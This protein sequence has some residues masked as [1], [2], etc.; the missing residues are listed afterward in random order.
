[1]LLWFVSF[2]CCHNC[3]LK[4][5]DKKHEWY[6]FR[7]QQ[8]RGWH[9]KESFHKSKVEQSSNLSLY[10][11]QLSWK[12]V[13]EK[14]PV[15]PERSVRYPGLSCLSQDNI[16]YWDNSCMYLKK[17]TRRSDIP[18][19]FNVTL[20]GAVRLFVQLSECRFHTVRS[21]TSAVS[22]FCCNSSCAQLQNVS[23]ALHSR[24]CR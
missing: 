10:L 11:Q 16:T 24:R 15:Q 22:R 19:C 1:M 17:N 8:S 23:H 13:R 3:T 5:F 4:I 12:V 7:K 20:L 21:E 6:H 2:F 14:G 9:F 18:D